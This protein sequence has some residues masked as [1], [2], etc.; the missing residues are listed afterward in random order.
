[1][2]DFDFNTLP[3]RLENHSMKW[4]E[5]EANRDLLPLW[6][7]DMDFLPFPKMKA[8][9]EAYAQR[10]DY[11]YP[12]FSDQVLESIQTWEK[13]EHGYGFEKEALVLIE[14]VVPAISVAIQAFS[15]EGEAVLINTPVYPPF[16]RSVKLN[17]RQ[18]VENSL[19]EKNGR[20]ELEF[21]QLEKDLVENQVKVYVFCSPHN[22]GGRVWSPEELVKVAELCRKH[23]VILVSDE[24]HQDLALFGNKHHSLNTLGDFKDF[25]LILGSA[26]KTFNVAGT[27]NSFAIIENPELRAIFKKRQLG[28]NQHEVPTIGLVTTETAFRYGRPWLT[29]LKKVLEENINLVVERLTRETQI[30]VM[31]PEGTYLVWLDF[32]AYGLDDE[33]LHRKIK[34]EA[35]LILNVGSTFGKEG[36]GHARLNVATPQATLKEALDRLSQ[37]F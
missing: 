33:E 30:K 8:A 16:A 1:M 37:V 26:T 24:I 9:V 29:R 25:T 15:K 21:E 19:V 13:E 34:E 11:G 28:N 32:S 7:A 14:G 35:K 12:Y 17:N 4:K 22:P 18:L 27:K 3:D 36:L 2:I 6:V 5:V 10:G 31:K 20:F 23:N